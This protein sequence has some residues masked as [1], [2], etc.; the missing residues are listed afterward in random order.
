M[1]V[2]RQPAPLP[3]RGEG[4]L[5]ADPN[6]LARVAL[7]DRLQGPVA[8]A[9]A[10][11]EAG[12]RRGAGGGVDAG[13]ELDPGQP[14]LPRGQGA[15]LVDAD[16]VDRGE[17]LTGAHLLDQGVASRQPHRGDGEGD[18]HQQHQALGDQRHQPGG[19]GLGGFVEADAAD[20]EGE[21]QDRRQRDHHVGAGD[22][23]A[24]DL[25]LEGGGGMAEGARL[26]G[27]A[28]GVALLAD[29]VDDVVAGAGDAEGAGEDAVAEAL[30][31]PV[32]LA[33]Q[34]RLVEGHAAGRDRLAV[35]DQLVA[36]ADG[37]HV[38][39]DDL[40]REQLDDGAVADDPGARRDQ[41]RQLVEGRLRLQLLADA[42]VGVDHRDQA[43]DRVRVE[44]QRQV[45]DE[46]DADDRVE[47]GEDVAGDDA[48]DRARGGLRRRSQLAQPRRRLGAGQALL[49]G[50][51]AVSHSG[52]Q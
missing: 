17:A 2:E 10:G 7:G 39:G 16:R 6:R 49:G 21:D 5:G 40:G 32:G 14:Q 9:G 24:V 29:R 31:D 15:G 4:D 13:G 25:D 26:A 43:E 22:D 18:A 12:Q 37:D 45:E 47:E 19:R 34:Q 36:G 3:L 23:D 30:L 11:G 50:W 33:G 28:A 41:D 38:A 27:E 52:I 8:V 20:P 44:A 42:D 46:E 35:G 1:S 48:R 51:V